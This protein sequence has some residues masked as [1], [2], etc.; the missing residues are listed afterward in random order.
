MLTVDLVVWLVAAV[1]PGAALIRLSLPSAGWMP[2]LACAPAISFGF[3]Y[4]IGLACSRASASPVNGV[5]IGTAALVALTMTTEV[6]RTPLVRSESRRPRATRRTGDGLGTP[7]PAVLISGLL[8]AG[9]VALGVL[10]WRSFQSSMLVPVGWDA[11]HHGYFIEQIS[12]LHTMKSS[13][14]LSSD[15]GTADGSGT[16]YPLAFNLVAATLH[17]CF[18]G[19]ISTMM[20]AST[21]AIA[22]VLLPL[23]TYAL[24]RELDPDQPLVAGFAA[25]ASELP[26]MLYV[27]EGTGRLTGILGI[28]LV[29]GLVALLLSQHGR[30]RW[31]TVPIV[32]FGVLGVAGVHTSEAPLAVLT[33]LACGLVWA[34]QEGDRT[35]LLRWLG[36]LVVGGGIAVSAL[37]LLEPNVLSLVSERGGAIITP[38]RRPTGQV[39]RAASTAIGGGGWLAGLGCGVTL[40]PQ[41]RRYRGVSIAL[42]ALTT[43]YLAVGVGFAT[44][45]PTL[46]IPWYGDPARIAWDLAFAGAL[47]VAVGITAVA[48]LIG[49]PALAAARFVLA[50][51]P[52][53][54]SQVPDRLVERWARPAAVMITGVLVVVAST[55]PPVAIEGRQVSDVAGP[56]DRNSEAAFRYLAA[57]VHPGEQVLDDLRTDGAMWMY[58][59]HG[60]EPIFGNSPLL[61]H[62]PRSW[63]ERLWLSRN[64]K[65]IGSDPCVQSMLQKFAVRYVYAGDIR[66][67]DG[68]ADFDTAVMK[69]NPAFTEVF[70]QGPAHVFI[71]NPA[72]QASCAQD[73]TVTVR[74]G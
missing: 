20:L 46:A 7:S 45:V 5:L 55:L 57:H 51:K 34:K 72:P 60:V 9:G 40:L 36:W 50:P 62:A 52:G 64:L 58:V 68:W 1:T 56:V 37:I 21:S 27:I 43:L 16:F 12:R 32:A 4:A 2:T 15:P 67:F 33:V 63:L 26:L 48:G 47:P 66:M 41:W 61:G 22:G 17:A 70:R 54:V 14:V 13:V 23:G 74:W 10:Q 25:I 65:N 35:S 11:M 19:A 3:C 24:A 71:L 39:L 18:G 30:T 8:L 42:A 49:K 44:V 29:P 53:V 59:D 31:V 6:R 38:T 73:V 69:R 28:A